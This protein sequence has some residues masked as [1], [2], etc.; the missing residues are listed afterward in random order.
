M[1]TALLA[2]KNIVGEQHDIWNVNVERSYHEN[3]TNEEWSKVKQDAQRVEE[4]V[5][6]LSRAA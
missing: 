4:E 1:L 2:A 5:S 3:F 6:S